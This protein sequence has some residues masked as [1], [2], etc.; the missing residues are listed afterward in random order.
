[1]LNKLETFLEFCTI[2]G[3]KGCRGSSLRAAPRRVKS[4]RSYTYYF[5]SLHSWRRAQFAVVDPGL[6]GSCFREFREDQRLIDRAIAV[7]YIGPRVLGPH[8]HP[9]K[10]DLWRR[11]AFLN[12]WPAEVLIEGS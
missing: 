10:I 2:L 11:E 3:Q 4:S 12:P 6:Q 5:P 7:R 8:H 1:M 9:Q